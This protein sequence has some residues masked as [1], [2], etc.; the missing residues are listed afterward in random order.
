MRPMTVDGSSS[1]WAEILVVR[2]MNSHNDLAVLTSTLAETDV[3]QRAALR[4]VILV[5]HE[6]EKFKA[7][8]SALLDV[9]AQLDL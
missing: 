4:G 5:L 8:C 1:D 9:L 7:R 2:V 3:E 6:D